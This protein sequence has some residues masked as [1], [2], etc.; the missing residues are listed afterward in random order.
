MRSV[1]QQQHNGD[2]SFIAPPTVGKRALIVL[3]RGTAFTVLTFAAAVLWLPFRLI[4]FFTV[5]FTIAMTLLG[6][7]AVIFHHDYAGG[8]MALLA[9]VLG[10]FIAGALVKLRTWVL[11]TREEF[12]W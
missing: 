3:G 1:L 8:V 5:L 10:F 9:I 12:R 6:Y 2:F 4:G 7:I 11:M